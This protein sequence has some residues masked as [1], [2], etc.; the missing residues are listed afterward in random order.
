MQVSNRV[1]DDAHFDPDVDN[2]PGWP[3]VHS[4]V[5][6]PPILRF[7]LSENTAGRLNR[8]VVRLHVAANSSESASRN[9]RSNGARRANWAQTDAA[10]SQSN[11]GFPLQGGTPEGGT[12]AGKEKSFAQAGEGFSSGTEDSFW[13][14]FLLWNSFSSGFSSLLD[15]FV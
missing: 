8:G 1:A 13:G 9:A 15:L 2:V 3:R 10:T 11:Q 4:M 6:H 14:S 7:T 12:H 5:P